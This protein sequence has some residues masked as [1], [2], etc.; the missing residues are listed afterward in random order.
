MDSNGII[1]DVVDS[2]PEKIATVTYPS[3]AKVEL[4]NELTPTQ[5]KDVPNVTWEAEADGIYA[6]LMV[7]PDAP[8]REKPVLRE[9]L[10]WSVINIPGNDL[11]KGQ[12]LVEYVGAGPLKDS[13]LH[14]Y[15]FWVFKQKSVW[16]TT[17]FTSKTT[18]EGRANIKT[19]D[20][21]TK[22]QMG[23]PIAGNYF[24]A[25][26]DSYVDTLMASFSPQ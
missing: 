22:Y 3:G 20:Y 15:I 2:V 11:A 4:G 6:V 12:T 8:S 14:R 9:I 21:I 19:R 16:P 26:Y 1:P 7:D 13:G 5:V 10:H 17:N 24:Q 23:N 18:R 25:Q